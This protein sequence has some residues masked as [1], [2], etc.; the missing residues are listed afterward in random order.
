MFYQEIFV[1]EQTEWVNTVASTLPA[2]QSAG[3][4]DVYCPLRSPEISGEG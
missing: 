1:S 3:L 4:H 2:Q